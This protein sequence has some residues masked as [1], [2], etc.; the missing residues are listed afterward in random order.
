VR[1]PT[2]HRRPELTEEEARKAAMYHAQFNSVS[3]H[4]FILQQLPMIGKDKRHIGNVL[5]MMAGQYGR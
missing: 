4:R 1:I 2:I 3:V 5:A